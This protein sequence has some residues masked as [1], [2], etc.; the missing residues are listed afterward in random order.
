MIISISI[1][2]RGALAMTVLVA[3][4]PWITRTKEPVCLTQILMVIV[5]GIQFGQAA[6]Q[7]IGLIKTVRSDKCTQ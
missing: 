4:H 3:Q 5:G 6:S 2:R 7:V 1:Y